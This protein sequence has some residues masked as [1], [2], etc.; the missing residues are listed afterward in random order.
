MGRRGTTCRIRVIAARGL[1]CAA[2]LLLLPASGSAAGEEEPAPGVTLYGLAASTVPSGVTVSPDGTIWFTA[3]Q[4]ASGRRLVGYLGPDGRVTELE[5]P[6]ARVASPV[7]DRGGSI[8]FIGFTERIGSNIGRVTATGEITEFP[9]SRG[10]EVSALTV[11]PDGNV[12]F[13]DRA[14]G[15]IGRLTPTGEV[16]YFRL[17]ARSRPTGIT[18]GPDGNVWFTLARADKIGRISMSGEIRLFRLPPT[19]LPRAIVAGPDG[20]LWFAEGSYTKRGRKG[21]NKI[22]RISPEGAVTQFRVRAPSGT[23]LIAAGPSGEISFTTG[24]SS[25]IGSITTSGVVTR[26]ACIDVAC[27]M[28]V[29]AIAQDAEGAIWFGAGVPHCGYCGGGTTIIRDLTLPGHIGRLAP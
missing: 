20:N 25:Q 22:G 10:S 27:R 16:S 7:S 9:L 17:G 14:V 18:A 24:G 5:V 26:Y 12:W 21:R 29:Y 11:G 3:S 8:W 28:P 4:L 2:F 6:G 13:T 23:G 1:A 15:R 19:T